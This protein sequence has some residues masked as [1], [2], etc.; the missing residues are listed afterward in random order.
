LGNPDLVRAAEKR[1]AAAK[2]DSLKGKEVNAGQ[3]E[4]EKGE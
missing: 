4:A 1:L 2:A 3:A